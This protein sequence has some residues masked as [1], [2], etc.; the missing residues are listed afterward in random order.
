MGNFQELKK[1]LGSVNVLYVEDES[2]VREE[3]LRFLQKIFANVDSASDGEEGLVRFKEKEYQLV[4]S[5]LKMPKMNGREMMEKIREINKD[6]VLIVMSAADSKMDIAISVC[7]D[8]VYKPVI[9]LDF[10]KTLE[11]LSDKILKNLHN[12]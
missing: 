8:Y 9:F 5:D 10:L 11:S 6:V 12:S 2:S 1:K 7:D 3:T 4:I